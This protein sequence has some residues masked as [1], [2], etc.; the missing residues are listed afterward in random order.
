MHANNGKDIMATWAM[1][2]ESLY[3]AQLA[4]IIIKD[5]RFRQI[6]IQQQPIF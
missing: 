1:Y 5:Q 6:Y 4:I 3:I 2:K